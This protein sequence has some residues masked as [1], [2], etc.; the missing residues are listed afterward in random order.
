MN[1][2]ALLVTMLTAALGLQAAEL[3]PDAVSAWDAYIQ[4]ASSRMAERA[5][6]GT[7]LWLD[8]LAGGSVRAR[9]GEIVIAPVGQHNPHSVPH[10]LIHDWVGAA[11]IPNVTLREV[12]PVVRD[13]S[14][15]KDFYQPTVLDSKTIDA[16]PEPGNQKDHFA[17]TMLNKALFLKTAL[18]TEC[19]ST[20]HQIDEKRWYSVAQ[21]T[22]VQQIDRY[23]QADQRRLPVDQGSGYIWRLHSFTRYQ[24]RDG[25]VYMELEVMALSRDIPLTVRLV[26][27]P[28][29]RRVSRNSLLIS[30]RQTSEAVRSAREV[31]RRWGGR[32]GATQVEAADAG[33]IN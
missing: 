21:T 24:E 17:I 29:V 20:F 13:Y 31:A 26:A 1:R 16:K 33:R 28:I 23:G 27:E 7:F 32:P 5:G 10:G 18:E 19:D 6:H 25:G 30:L 9:N 3:K 8:E 4:A 2:R 22:R 11:F 14:R 12:L 15:Y